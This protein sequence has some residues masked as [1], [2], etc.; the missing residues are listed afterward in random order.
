MIPVD[1]SVVQNSHGLATAGGAVERVNRAA[2]M[3][4]LQSTV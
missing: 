4:R 3:Q 1:A 2:T